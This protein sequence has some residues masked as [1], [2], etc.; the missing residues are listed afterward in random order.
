[1]MGQPFRFREQPARL[2]LD[3]FAQTRLRTF[4]AQLGATGVSSTRACHVEF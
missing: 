4:N 2:T 3:R 1:M